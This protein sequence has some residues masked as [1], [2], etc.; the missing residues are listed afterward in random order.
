MS[1]F[2]E[3]EKKHKWKLREEPVALNDGFL[4]KMYLFCFWEISRNPNI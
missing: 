2:T 1:I 4:H 3:I